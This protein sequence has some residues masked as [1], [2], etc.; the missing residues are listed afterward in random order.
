MI[1]DNQAIR[2]QHLPKTLVHL[3]KVELMILILVPVPFN[4]TNFDKSKSFLALSQNLETSLFV[5]THEETQTIYECEAK[6]LPRKIINM[7]NSFPPNQFV[8][9]E[10]VIPPRLQP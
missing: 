4:L 1:Q 2:I 8:E 3:R 9:I 10:E 5:H 7:N 6:L